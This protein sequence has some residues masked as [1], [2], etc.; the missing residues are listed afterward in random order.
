M[1]SSCKTQECL[2]DAAYP[3][4]KCLA[5][6]CTL[7]HTHLS[8]NNCIFGGYA[9][10]FADCHQGN[11][12]GLENR[13]DVITADYAL[14]EAGHQGH[15]EPCDKKCVAGQDGRCK[16][17]RQ[18]FDASAALCCVY[19]CTF[20]K[21]LLKQYVTLSMARLCACFDRELYVGWCLG[22]AQSGC[23]MLPHMQPW[24]RVRMLNVKITTDR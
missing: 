4:D 17:E 21:L 18:A 8:E 13:W 23:L 7:Y 10:H 19:L 14:G 20:S 22:G 5:L 24:P 2:K 15:S 12:G 9:Q 3:L 1:Y 6:T 11:L 16:D